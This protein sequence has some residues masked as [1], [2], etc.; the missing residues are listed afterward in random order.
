PSV[1]VVADELA[2][3]VGRERGLARS[4]KPKEEGGVSFTVRVGGA[5]HGQDALSD[6]KYEIEHRK[7][8]FLDFARIARAREQHDLLFETDYDKVGAVDSACLWIVALQA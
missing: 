4:G 5:V 1:L 2:A 6:W 7:D 3:N 8:A